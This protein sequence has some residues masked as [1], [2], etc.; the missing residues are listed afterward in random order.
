MSLEVKWPYMT[1]IKLKIAQLKL[2]DS[3]WTQKR[4]DEVKWA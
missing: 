2:N 1:L 3:E 4:P